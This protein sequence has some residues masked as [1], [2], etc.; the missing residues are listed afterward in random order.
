MNA[1]RWMLLV[2]GLALAA[3]SKPDEQVQAVPAVAQASAPVT[4]PSIDAFDTGFGAEVAELLPAKDC[5]DCE[6]QNVLAP[7][8][9]VSKIG[10]MTDANAEPHC[11]MIVEDFLPETKA[12]LNHIGVNS[13]GRNLYSFSMTTTGQ[14][15]TSITCAE[16]TEH[17]SNA[18]YVWAEKCQVK[19]PGLVEGEDHFFFAKLERLTPEKGGGYRIRFKF[20]HSPFGGAGRPIHN[21]EGHAHPD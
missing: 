21:G 19:N 4:E 6:W 14:P 9:K 13:A 5:K 15:D 11:H 12:D 16:L 8:L 2:T 1:F 3:C 17:S 10:C 20:Q 18:A 7:A